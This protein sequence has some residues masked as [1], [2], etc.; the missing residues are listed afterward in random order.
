[1]GRYCGEPALD[2]VLSDPIVQA[3][4]AADGIDVAQTC[5]ILLKAR[6]A[7][8]ARSGEACNRARPMGFG[9]RW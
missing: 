3:L 8:A 2:E 5:D 7:T 1:M 4:M 6:C 9:P